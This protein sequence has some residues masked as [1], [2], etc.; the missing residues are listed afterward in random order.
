M[1]GMNA[2]YK[3]EEGERLVEGRYRDLLARWPVPSEERSIS[4]SF[5]NTFV[6]ACGNAI[7]AFGGLAPGFR[8]ERQRCG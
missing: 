1:S 7:Q 4:T 3:S 8:R 2:I 6:V 5:G